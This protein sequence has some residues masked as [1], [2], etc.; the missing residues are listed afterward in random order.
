MDNETKTTATIT[1]G[2][3]VLT[4]T[5]AKRYTHA[6]KERIW[7]NFSGKRGAAKHG[8][9]YSYGDMTVNALHGRSSSR[10]GFITRENALALA[11]MMGV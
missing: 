11:E 5:K 2:R 8:V 7:F 10:V 4:C 3:S 9:L 1:V 6:G